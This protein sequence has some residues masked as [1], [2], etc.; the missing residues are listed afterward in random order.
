MLVNDH[1]FVVTPAAI[2]GVTRRLWSLL[3][4]G[5]PLSVGWLRAVKLTN[6]PCLTMVDLTGDNDR[7][8]RNAI[9][10]SGFVPE[11]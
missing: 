4:V 8:A 10:V 6:Y 2:A 1:S 7:G 3:E 11:S 5:N 9:T